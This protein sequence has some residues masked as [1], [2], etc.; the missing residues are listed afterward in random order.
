MDVR[1]LMRRAAS[2]FADREAVVKWIDK[3]LRDYVKQESKKPL[4]P[5][6]R[7]LTNF[8]YQNSKEKR[9]FGTSSFR[10]SSFI[11]KPFKR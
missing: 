5:T 10:F 4:P 8:E 9:T 1:T 2:H 7:R 3:G 6:A 11:S